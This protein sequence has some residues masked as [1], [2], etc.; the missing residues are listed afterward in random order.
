MATYKQIQNETKRQ[1]GFVPKTC[2]IA[3]IKA[4]NG[5]TSRVAANREGED[6]KYPCPAEKR[7]RLTQVMRTLGVV[8]AV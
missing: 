8:P 3:D 6:R 4:E 1:F 2:W 7:T 5:L